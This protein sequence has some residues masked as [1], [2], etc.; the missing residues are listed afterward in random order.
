[1]RREQIENVLSEAASPPY[2]LPVDP[3][4]DRKAEL[5][6]IA[7]ES[8]ISEADLSVQELATAG[9][10]N[11]T[12]I[13]ACTPSSTESSDRVS[14]VCILT[15]DCFDRVAELMEKAI[16]LQNDPSWVEE[17]EVA[18]QF[19]DILEDRSTDAEATPADG[20]DDLEP[21]F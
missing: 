3:D 4:K 19:P 11:P 13:H 9:Q 17:L 1:M 20:N 7:P 2:T 16:A 5:F 12:N 14:A 6:V 21:L 15:D 18:D 8:Y 10:L